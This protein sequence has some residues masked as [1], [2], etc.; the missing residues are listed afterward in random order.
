MDIMKEGKVEVF[1]YVQN[2][3]PEV[4]RACLDTLESKKVL[5][6]E[7]GN[8]EIFSVESGRYK[9][10]CLK[11]LRKT[12]RLIGNDI[13]TE[14]NF[15]DALIDLGIRTPKV[16]ARLHD[17]A[18]NEK[19][20]I[21]ERINGPSIEDILLE[22]VKVPEGYKHKEFWRKMKSIVEK[23]HEEGDIYHRDL[24]EG[25]IMIDT[26][27]GCEPVIIDFGT[28]TRGLGDEYPYGEEAIIMDEN[29]GAYTKTKGYYKSD[30]SKIAGLEYRMRFYDRS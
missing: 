26:E 6:G 29:T 8:A 28:A 1:E 4:L 3:D 13:D 10:I 18:K 20:I 11:K 7:G 15:Q 14:V 22:R 5:I 23:M 30:E 2:L 16:L 12:P 24:H 21:M 19:Y 9:N 17:V 25:N 27:N